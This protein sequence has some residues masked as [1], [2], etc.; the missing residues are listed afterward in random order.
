M[1]P[2]R[3]VAPV[4]RHPAS[5]A[6]IGILALVLATTPCA[7]A[8]AGQGAP[9]TIELTGVDDASSDTPPT[10]FS[11]GCLPA[12]GS[13]IPDPDAPD[14]DFVFVGGGWGHGAGMS[15]YGAQGAGRLGCTAEQILT[16][17]FTGTNVASAAMPDKVIIGLAAAATA[18]DVTASAGTIPWELC[19]YQTGD[20]SP[21]PVQ[22]GTGAVW[23]VQVRSD[24]TYQITHGGT[25][26]WEGGDYEHNL[27]AALSPSA[28]IDHRV[29]VSSTGHT[30]R[31]GTLQIDSVARG[32]AA[33]AFVTLEIPSMELYLRGLAEVPASWPAATLQAQAI[34]GRSYAL[35]R[36][37]NL[38]AQGA[39]R[40]DCRCHLRDTPADQNYEG[41][42]Y[43]RA[44]AGISG[45]WRAA[46]EGTAG[47]VLMHQGS[48]AETFYSSSHG[49]H[50]ESA[51]FVF[52]G[53]LPY[54]QPVDDS[55]W[56]LASTN[57]LRR[58]TLAITAGQLGEAAGVGTATSIEL[59]EPRG[60]AGR[61][62]NP[63]RGY[64]GARITGTNGSSLLSGDQVK[65]R[66]GLRSTLFGLAGD[67]TAPPP[68]PSEPPPGP[69][70][71]A[72]DLLDRAAGGD[73]VATAVAVARHGWDAA[74]DVILAAA[75]RFPDALAGVRLA[76]SLEAP[77]L[78]TPTGGLADGVRAELARL[79]TTT[80]WMLGGTSALSSDVR[81]D[82][83]DLGIAT[84]RLAGPD[85]YATARAIAEASASTSDEVTVALGEDWPDAVSSA[86][87]A[88]LLDGPPTLLVR[89]DSV[90]DATVQ[91][92]H[93][94]GATRVNVVGGTAVVSD[95][96]V[97][98]LSDLGLTVQRLA[99]GDRFATAAV[100]AGEALDRRD[101][102]S[103]LIVASGTGF[104]DALAAGAL[105]AREG[106]IL[107]LAPM[108]TMAD[109]AAAADF[110]QANAAQLDGGVVIG[111]TSVISTTVEGQLEQ[112]LAQ[113]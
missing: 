75:D 16:T 113:G 17:Y 78:L 69:T 88:A 99:G 91:A 43:E 22:Q 64:G 71:P 51:R 29:L 31:W 101:K 28:D 76:A 37:Q 72:P 82:L 107:L 26:V 105:A 97:Q 1:N 70:E 19:H 36:I 41:Y 53:D 111:G 94:L 10:G 57:P 109:G 80:V 9:P 33:D 48:V 84:R 42:D 46:V 49:G 93:Q 12:G 104:A 13:A 63:A 52:G 4:R 67:G 50:S 23:A 35:R 89:R 3:P 40:D 55:R 73:R 59:L 6:L 81:G 47:Q 56:D 92:I 96:V 66:L 45:A 39:L 85:R 27:R 61:V 65:Q 21:L 60:A 74:P 11:Q 5:L 103:P 2:P 54:V 62:G 18:L 34:S 77:L 44:D 83:A 100:V 110:V 24:A 90:P 102:R 58:W 14:G 95:T 79:G 7:P 106:G 25:T 32:A 86:S 38:T 68:D 98:Q 108:A 15:Q 8:S 20:C 30:Y 87:L 112:L